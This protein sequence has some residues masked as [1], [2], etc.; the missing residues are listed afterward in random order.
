[1]EMESPK[2][3][4]HPGN[5]PH[6]MKDDPIVATVAVAGAL[7]AAWNVLTQ[8]TQTT[9]DSTEG[10]GPPGSMIGFYI[11]HEWGY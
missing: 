1:M 2:K 11:T 6:A 7:C 9:G 3:C 10:R 8:T 4:V 5:L